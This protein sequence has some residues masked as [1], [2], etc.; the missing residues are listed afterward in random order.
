MKVG[1]LFFS[2]SEELIRNIKLTLT[3]PSGREDWWF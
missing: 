1:L 3:K 2:E